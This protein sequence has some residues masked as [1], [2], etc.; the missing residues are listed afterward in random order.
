MGR[1]VPSNRIRIEFWLDD[2]DVGW[3]KVYDNVTKDE[4]S[5]NSVQTPES[6]DFFWKN[7]HGHCMS[8][9]GLPHRDE[10]P[11]DR[12]VHEVYRFDTYYVEVPK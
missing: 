6:Y 2:H 4:M 7:C 3:V 5:F 10:Y 1:P 8:D 11:D 12:G 9:R